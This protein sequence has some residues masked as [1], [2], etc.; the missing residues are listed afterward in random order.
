MI[1]YNG[2]GAIVR[3]GPNEVIINDPKALDIVYGFGSDFQ[4]VTRPYLSQVYDCVLMSDSRLNSIGFSDF[5]TS[6]ECMCSA[7]S[8]ENYTIN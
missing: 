8:V 1:S 2:E 4:K 5:Q 6:T 3:T 7:R